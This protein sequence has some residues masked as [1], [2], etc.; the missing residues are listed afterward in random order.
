[1]ARK[2]QLTDW[3]RNYEV[4]DPANLGGAVPKTQIKIAGKDAGVRK[5][6]K[7]GRKPSK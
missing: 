6:G 2:L 5:K 1:M 4:P 7:K 3:L